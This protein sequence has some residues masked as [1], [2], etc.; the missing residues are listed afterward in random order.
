MLPVVDRKV[1]G[2]TLDYVTTAQVRKRVDGGSSAQL[3]F[4]A[5]V[6]VLHIQAQVIRPIDDALE[7][8]HR[9]NITGYEVLARLQ[10]IP[11]GASV[12]F[13]SD[14]VVVSPSRVSRVIEDFVSRGLLE[15]AASPHDG[16]LSL[17][18]V[19]P[20]CQDELARMRTT[21][22]QAL[23][24]HFLTRLTATQIRGLTDIGRRLGAPHC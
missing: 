10:Q 16:R 8:A 5:L 24:E 22:E 1:A 23:D 12:R 21:F 9:T 4:E 13:L 19:T 3:G 20:K 14:Q 18:T 11:Q 6:A 7:R 2:D 15:R 17:V